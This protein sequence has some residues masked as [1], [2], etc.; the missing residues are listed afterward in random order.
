MYHRNPDKFSLLF[1]DDQKQILSSM[2]RIFFD[3][4]YSLYTASDAENALDLLEKNEIHAALIDLKMPGMDG[5]ELLKRMMSDYPQI[6]VV[7]VTGHGNIRDA[8]EAIKNGAVDFIEKPFM[9]ENLIARVNQLYRLWK[10]DRE[11]NL[12]KSEIACHFNYEKFIGISTVAM[13]LKKFITKVGRCDETVLI[14]GETGTG[15]EVVAKAIHHHSARSDNRFAVVDCTTINENMLESEL[16]GHLKGS[17]TGAY[18]SSRGVVMAADRGTLFLDEIGEMPMSIQAKMLRLIQEKEIRPVGSDTPCKVDVRILAATNRDLGKEIKE[19]RFRED[20]YYRL[21]AV[22]INVPPLRK[23]VEDIHPLTE[24]FIKKHQTD[25]SKPDSIS[26]ESLR[27]MEKY[28]WPGNIRE[29]ENVIRRIMALSSGKVIEPYDFPEPIYQPA[30]SANM[31]PLEDSLEAYEKAAIVN[32][33]AKTNNNRKEASKI[34]NIGE[35]TLY[36]KLKKYLLT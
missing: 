20:L 3:E 23:R 19:K 30:S 26:R 8:V 1:V 10:L 35:A 25:F 5:Q 15:K 16:F 27:V 29:L 34:L 33:L 6:M 28:P 24:H 36:R 17:F 13:E 31:A 4:D 14:Q 7:M 12:L 22:T 9:P 21:S 11:N 32:A 18:A 2:K